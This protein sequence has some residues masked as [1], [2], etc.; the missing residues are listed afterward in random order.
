MND[1]NGASRRGG[2]RRTEPVLGNLDLVD[3][4]TDRHGRIRDVPEVQAEPDGSR[5]ER[6]RRR[7]TS[8]QRR[9]WPWVVAAIVVLVA[10]SWAFSHRASLSALLP[11]TQLNSLLS[12]ADTAYAAGRLSGGPDSA[13][14]LYEA[15]RV[16]SPDNEEAANGLQNVGKAELARA[17]DAL[18]KHDY[19]AARSALE[20]ARSLLGGG[21]DIQAVD[22]ELAQAVLHSANVDVLVSQAR[23]ALANGRIDGGDGAAA[24]FRKV[25]A[26][27]PDN[28]I[29]RH[30]MDQIGNLLS[31][32]VQSQLQ[33]GDRAGAHRTLD[34]LAGLL[35]GYAGLPSLRASVAAADRAVDAK[36]D[37]YL[38]Q[39]NAYL[40][41][42]KLAG[43]GG[44]NA[45]AQFKAALAA[46]PGNAQAQTGLGEVAEALATQA[47]AALVAGRL[48]DARR[49]LDQAS[50]LAP[51]SVDIAAA[52]LRLAAA[53][54]GTSAAPSAPASTP[55]IT[56][57][58]SA[59]LARLIA[60]ARTAAGR[61]DIMLPPGD[62]AYDLYRAA[63]GIDGN[64]AAAQAGLRALPQA[65][66]T[67]FEQAVK[68]DNLDHAR[69]MLATLEQLDP[70]DPAS[71]A[72]RRTLGR[73]WLDRASHYASLG[74]L[75]PA[76]AALAE[77]RAL[78]PQ[79]PR[80]SEVDARIHR[81][82]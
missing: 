5:G 54:S 58:D 70:G 67:Q 66:R 13:R 51:K 57:A 62:S 3:S 19:Q 44:D 55:A 35:P 25:L 18:A 24:L 23:A 75:A 38:A 46:D 8:R 29:A 53:H 2:S 60:R 30:G 11:Q 63:L 41:A 47:N 74:Q 72:M 33:Q 45:E 71:A 37:Q 39:G 4:S 56:P 42:G 65:T 49:L 17:R 20:E 9:W 31:G 32:R 1:R 82:D 26:G 77:A 52:R 40:R 7:T 80:I 27:D 6:S 73:A 61:G 28:A 22:R 34:R 14:D 78:V 50:A 12:R 59:K 43:S 64:S 81:N 15:A 79:D 48:D 21:A 68:S 76:R 16:L 69:D 36:R 10:G